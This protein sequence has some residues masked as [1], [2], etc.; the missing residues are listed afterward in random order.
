MLNVARRGIIL[1]FLIVGAGC[2]PRQHY[3]VYDADFSHEDVDEAI[4]IVNAFSEDFGFFLFESDRRVETALTG[5]RDAFAIYLYEDE[6]MF[7]TYRGDIIYIGNT[8]VGTVLRITVDVT[9][10]FSESDAQE[11]SNVLIGRLSG[12]LGLV[13]NKVK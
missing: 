4:S 11:T 2:S 1:W 7:G 5:G 12:D 8:G 9:E 13:F 10:T 3:I 6:S